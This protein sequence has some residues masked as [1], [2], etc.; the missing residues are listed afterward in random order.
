MLLVFN[1]AT[2]FV[3]KSFFLFV[4]FA[5]LSPNFVNAAYR[6]RDDIGHLGKSSYGQ[7]GG[8]DYGAARRLTN[9]QRLALG[10]A[11]EQ[12]CAEAMWYV[13]A[14]VFVT[15]MMNSMLFCV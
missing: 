7:L 6:A 13:V 9:A 5:L 14:S 1:T 3:F 10:A 4:S 8:H 12:A 15:V 2:T 11:I